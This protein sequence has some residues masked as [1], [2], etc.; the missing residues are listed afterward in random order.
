MPGARTRSCTRGFSAKCCSVEFF[1]PHRNSRRRLYLPH[2]LRRTST[3]RFGRPR[4]HEKRLQPTQPPSE[5]GG[6]ERMHEVLEAHEG[7]EED[8]LTLPVAVTL[9][10]LAVL[11]A[12]ATLLGHRGSPEELMLP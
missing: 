2:T 11:V 4:S 1:W 10:I 6:D 9:S 12:I 5:P 7:R 8:P 3:A